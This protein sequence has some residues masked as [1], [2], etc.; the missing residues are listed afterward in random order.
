M[1]AAA[2][3]GRGSDDG[4]EAL[5]RWVDAARSG[6][7]SA[8]GRLWEL[9]SPRVHGYLR[10]RGVASP[11]DVTSEV[12]LA[13]FTGMATFTGDGAAFR[14]WLFTIAHHKAVDDLRRRTPTT[15]WT[16]ENDPRAVDSAED[17]AFEG[18]LGARVRGMLDVLTPDQREVLLLRAVGDLSIEEVAAVT[19]RTEGAVK[20]LFHRAVATARKAEPTSAPAIAPAPATVYLP[21]PEPSASTYSTLPVTRAA[22]TAMTEL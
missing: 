14:S 18:L 19:G 3:R 10:G 6:D 17:T 11:E 13:A 2:R 8:F 5:S 22:A 7:S 16:P 4:A 9:L 21:L 1:R 12:F 15:E 20:Q